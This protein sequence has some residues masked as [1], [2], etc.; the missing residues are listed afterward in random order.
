MR[1]NIALAL[2]AILTLA[3]CATSPPKN[4]EN[5]CSIFYEKDDWHDSAVK[6]TKRWGVPIQVPMAMMYQESSFQHDARP[7]KV[8]VLG[9]IPWGRV[10]S[11]YGYSQA[12][13]GT[14]RQYKHETGRSG[15]DRDSFDDSLDFM[16]WYVTKTHKING[17][18]KWSAKNQYL[19]YH[20]GWGGYR[21]HSYL[22]KPWLVRVAAKVDARSRRY[23]N[24]YAG[25]KEDLNKGFWAR[26]FS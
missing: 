19:N 14:W 11:A 7:P 10:S 26:L 4:P 3:G 5:L 21:R 1:I 8:Y 24:Q 23:A 16:G 17:V 12:L 9:F 15:A 6:M 2:F 18:S 25:C 22:K 13:D 20:D